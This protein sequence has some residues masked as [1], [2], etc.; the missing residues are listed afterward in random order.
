[1]IFLGLIV[2]L[3]DL[4]I[5]SSTF[6]IFICSI[7][8]L[9]IYNFDQVNHSSICENSELKAF[10]KRKIVGKICNNWATYLLGTAISKTLESC[11]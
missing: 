6:H 8:F 9:A 10:D 7:L 3:Y 1:M 5:L 2:A 11:I 4:F